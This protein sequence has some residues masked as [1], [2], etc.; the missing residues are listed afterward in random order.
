[1]SEERDIDEDVSRGERDSRELIAD[2]GEEA[3]ESYDLDVGGDDDDE[4]SLDDEFDDELDEELESLGGGENDS[5]PED[6]GDGELYGD[7]DSSEEETY[8]EAD[9]AGE[10]VY[11]DL[12]HEASEEEGEPSEFGDS[13]DEAVDGEQGGEDDLVGEVED[14]LAGDDGGEG[15]E[16]VF[17]D[18]EDDEG[19]DD[20]V[21]EVE[22]ALGEEEEPEESGSQE[23]AVEAD[24]VQETAEEEV[25]EAYS[26]DASPSEG[27]VE[28]TG[29]EPEADEDPD[30]EET[31]EEAGTEETV[32]FDEDRSDE[33]EDE[34]FDDSDEVEDEFF[35]EGD[36]EAETDEP[37]ETE[38]WD[39]EGSEAEP[40]DSVE[41]EAGDA[42]QTVEDHQADQDGDAGQA[43]AVEGSMEADAGGDADTAEPGADGAESD[44]S[45][46]MEA[47][48]GAETGESVDSTI[49]TGDGDVDVT[50]GADIEG[51]EDAMTEAD[52][53]SD[54]FEERTSGEAGIGEMDEVEG[55]FEP[56]SELEESFGQDKLNT[57]LSEAKQGVAE[58]EGLEGY[59][60]H[61]RYWVNKP[62]AYVAILYSDTQNDHMYYVVEPRLD[63][64]EQTVR[65][66]LEERLRDVLMYEEVDNELEEEQILEKKVK[67]IIRDYGIEISS[68][69]MHKILYYLKR[70]YIHDGKIDPIMRD[71]AI[72]D[73]SCDGDNVPIFVYHRDYRDLMSNVEFEKKELDS[74]VIKLAQKAG[75]HISV[76]DPLVDASMPDGSRIQMTLGTEVTDR[77][78]TF[79]IR[80]FKD[81][82][83]TPIDL[84][85]FNT[86]SL[87][88]MAY[89]WTCIENNKSLIFAGGTASGKTTSMNA[90]TL[91]IPPKSKVISI[92]DTREVT[93]P[94]MNW[95]PS[96]TRDSF[97]DDGV[98]AVDEYELLR[99]ALRQRP[100]YLVVGEVRGEEALTLFQAMSTG[101]TTYSTMHAD[102]VDSAIHRL[103]NPP[104]S[105]P[106][107]MLKAL[108]IVSIQSQTFVGGERVRRNMKLVEIIGI[109]PKTRNIRTDDIF[110][111]NA[112]TDNFVRTGNSTA[113]QDI[114]RARGWSDEELQRE[115][116]E[117][118]EVLQYMLDNEIAEYEDVSKIIQ[119]FIIDRD[120]VL[121][122]IREG[123][124]DLEALSELK[125]LNL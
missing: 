44:L 52:E 36:T 16:E 119:S 75:K 103:E 79:T 38:E 4:W 6:E 35:D 120:R 85:N 58:Y 81:E 74:F 77:G 111:W 24:A 27:T 108:D 113:L 115:L 42:A 61:E 43:E 40:E 110:Q 91:F 71:P 80:L 1:M 33:V 64:Y 14:A 101:H 63:E 7:L 19:G 88:Q 72:E 118:R 23:E 69:S 123:E 17:G 62:Y 82:P 105:V 56:G 54:F 2:G 37:V 66:D 109:D 73:I 26:I 116:D 84:I 39:L 124:I 68:D 47:D 11:G 48:T 117:R 30:V 50:G 125:T 76:A 13:V 18:L 5:E 67:K 98:G 45:E 122:Q 46:T 121:N 59:V 78:S 9:D 34:F 95:I 12:D 94:H 49:E 97:S 99:A 15:G 3:E 112:E 107:S 92:E 86:F 60:E 89:L 114:K 31:G 70:D 90:V 57:L 21:G 65:K 32:D 41:D 51:L 100:E 10:E 83:F 22:A 29:G 104:I 8:E 102:S 20:L 87:E 25:E 93:L 28:E 106:R 55:F 53:I 96:V